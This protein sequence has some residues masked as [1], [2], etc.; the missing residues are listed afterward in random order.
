MRMKL[1]NAVVGKL[2]AVI[3]C[4]RNSGY[5]RKLPWLRAAPCTRLPWLWGVSQDGLGKLSGVVACKRLQC[6]LQTHLWRMQGGMTPSALTL[7][8]KPSRLQDS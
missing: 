3:V 1:G 5:A 8:S 7:N 4:R 6:L 2:V